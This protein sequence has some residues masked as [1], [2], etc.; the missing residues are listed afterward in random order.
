MNLLDASPATSIG[1][2]DSVQEIAVQEVCAADSI[3]IHTRNSTYKFV[4]VN[5]TSRRGLLTG[6]VCGDAVFKAVFIEA[7]R[8][9]D[10]DLNHNPWHLTTGS[11]ALFLVESKD[12]LQHLMTSTII[13]LALRH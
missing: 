9:D 4:V 5:P 2:V 10:A 13:H 8:Q 6:G 7:R 3:M 12:G 1:T 11:R